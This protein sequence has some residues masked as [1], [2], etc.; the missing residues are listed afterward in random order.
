MVRNNFGGAE[1]IEK[2]VDVCKRFRRYAAF[3]QSSLSTSEMCILFYNSLIYPKARKL[4]VRYNLLENLQDIY[5][6]K[7]EHKDLIKGFQCKSPNK[8]IAEF[9]TV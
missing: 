4:Y 6:I 2:M 5:L 9:L 7:S 8:M 3:L 1:R